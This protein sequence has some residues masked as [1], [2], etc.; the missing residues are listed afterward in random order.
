MICAGARQAPVHV[1][2]PADHRLP[3]PRIE[4]SDLRDDHLISPAPGTSY[5]VLLERS[6][7]IAGYEAHVVAHCA[8]FDLA[9][10]LTAAGYGITLLPDVAVPCSLVAAHQP[11]DRP[12][13]R[14]LIATVP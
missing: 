9:A 5:A 6:C 7:A 12:M 1:A 3:G 13:L 14:L 2:V 4:L 8:D 10:A 11:G